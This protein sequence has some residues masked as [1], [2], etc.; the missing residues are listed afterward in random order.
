MKSPLSK[1]QFVPP[2]PTHVQPSPESVQHST[3]HSNP[4][5]VQSPASTP[6]NNQ[7]N[8]IR[9]LQIQEAFSKQHELNENSMSV[10]GTLK[11]P[12]KGLMLM[13]TKSWTL[14]NKT[15][16]TKHQDLKIPCIVTLRIIPPSTVTPPPLGSVNNVFHKLKWCHVFGQ[17]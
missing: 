4:V 6:N 1:C 15:F 14:S 3:I 2:A 5:H 11:A 8:D 12:L 13:W 17:R 9:F 10:S 7:Q 16:P